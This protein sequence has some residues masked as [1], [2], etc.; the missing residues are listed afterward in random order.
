MRRRSW[1][2]CLSRWMSLWW[3]LQQARISPHSCAGCL[4][5]KLLP[6][7][8]LRQIEIGLGKAIQFD[9]AETS[10]TTRLD[11]AQRFRSTRSLSKVCQLLNSIIQAAGRTVWFVD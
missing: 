10:W 3:P 5:C 6:D 11:S 2:W 4:V 1:R 8:G 7:S 9:C